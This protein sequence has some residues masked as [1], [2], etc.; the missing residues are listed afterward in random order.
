MVALF[1]SKHAL[2]VCL[3]LLFVIASW[4]LRR[5][6]VL[7]RLTFKSSRWRCRQFVRPCVRFGQ[8]HAS[9]DARSLTDTHS[10]ILTKLAAAAVRRVQ[11]LLKLA[12]AQ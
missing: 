6:V 2:L 1:G 8:T 4:L 9:V 10:L 7:L 12:Q 3:G 5:C 11:R